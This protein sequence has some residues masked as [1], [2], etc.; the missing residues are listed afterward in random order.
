[1]TEAERQRVTA[2][3]LSGAVRELGGRESMSWFD[4]VE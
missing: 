3:D 1:M 2:S 4:N